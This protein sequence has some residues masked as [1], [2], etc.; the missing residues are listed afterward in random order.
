[1]KRVFIGIFSLVVLGTSIGCSQNGS[2]D[3]T[4]TATQEVTEE[5]S[6]QPEWLGIY[7]GTL[8]CADCEGIKT[9]IELKGDN[10]FWR[11]GEYLGKDFKAKDEGAYTYDT[12]KNVITTVAQDNDTTQYKIESGA[13]KMLD[14]QGNEITGGLADH[15]ILKKAADVK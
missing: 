14:K 8:P 7:E 13:L 5:Q 3:E 11:E 4:D 9:S 6:A 15:Y 10:T 1:M 12:D 2:S